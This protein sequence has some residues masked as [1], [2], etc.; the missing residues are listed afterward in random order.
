MNAKFKLLGTSAGLGIP[1]FYCDCAACRE[2]RVNAC[3]ARTRSGALLDTGKERLLIDASPDLRTQLTREG[4]SAIDG[5][6]IT[7]WHYDH[8]GGIGDLE[9]YGKL[10]RKQPLKLYL[11]PSAVVDYKLAYPFLEDVFDMDCWEF[12]RRYRLGNVE[13]TVLPANHSIETGGLL[14]EGRKRLAYFTDTAGLPEPT[15]SRIHG[16]DVLICDATLNGEN[17]FPHAHMTVDQAV[18]LGRQVEA[19]RTVL[20]HLAIHYSVPITMAELEEKLKQHPSVAVA[21]DGMEFDL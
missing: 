9:Y 8:F 20:T 19:R 1:S 3:W 16:V 15:A 17:W 12:E 13:F 2:A 11:P 5:L 14:I 10:S 4:I 18:E 6:L 21:Y 7:H